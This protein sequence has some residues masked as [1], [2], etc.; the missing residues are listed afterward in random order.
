MSKPDLVVIGAIAGPHGV[1]G[2]A[3][4]KPFGDG[5]AVCS[6]GPFLDAKGEVFLTPKSARHGPSGLVLVAFEEP[7]TREEVQA[8]KSTKLYVPRAELP[9]LDEDEFY[10]T[11]LI[12]LSVEDLTGSA[13]GKVKSVQDFGAGDLL[14][15][16][17]VDGVS[18]LPFTRE[19]VPHIDIAGGKLVADPPEVDED[20]EDAERAR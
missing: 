6:Y 11:D 14:E 13:L 4:V 20:D 9:D 16:S 2:E 1:K 15:I 12:G 19:V 10:Y 8:L 7:L 17:G 5:D 18:F 3:R